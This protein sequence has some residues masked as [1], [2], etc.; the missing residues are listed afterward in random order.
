MIG[1]EN[2]ETQDQQML[3]VDG[4]LVG[5]ILYILSLVISIVLIINQRQR[6]QNKEGFLTA[7]ES[8]ILA[9]FNKIF[10]LLLLFLFLYLDYEAKDLAEKTNQDTSALEL[11]IIASIISL[12]PVLIGIYVVV[13]DF[14]NTNLQTA[15]IENPF[16]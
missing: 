16:A 10:V 11:Q 7:K 2:Q 1:L 4:Q 14:S 9:L 8:Q 3:I 5:T 6:S 15:E 12:V 13:T